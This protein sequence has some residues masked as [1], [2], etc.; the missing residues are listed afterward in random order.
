[1][2]RPESVIESATN[3]EVAAFFGMVLDIMDKLSVM[4]LAWLPPAAALRQHLGRAERDPDGNALGP[5][6]ASALG[7]DIPFRVVLEMVTNMMASTGG[8]LSYTAGLLER[9]LPTVVDGIVASY[10]RYGRYTSAT[11]GMHPQAGRRWLNLA[12]Q[13]HRKA[14]FRAVVDRQAAIGE[15]EHLPLAAAFAAAKL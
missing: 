6:A 11:S 3:A 10:V 15:D 7:P 9:A 8:G 2:D 1:M 12:L 5:W 4:D 13:D 14:W